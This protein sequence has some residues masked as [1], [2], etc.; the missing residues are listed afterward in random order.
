MVWAT[1][2]AVDGPNRRPNADP[3]PKEGSAKLVNAN[4][5]PPPARDAGES[6]GAA[7]RATAARLRQDAPGLGDPTKA[8]LAGL[9]VEAPVVIGAPA[10][11]VRVDQDQLLGHGAMIAGRCDGNADPAHGGP[12]MDTEG[13]ALDTE[14]RHW[15]R[16]AG[17]GHGGA[18]PDGHPH[19]PAGSI[20]AWLKSW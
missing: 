3:S 7:V 11:A 14:G 12:A 16:R 1:E 17:T 5:Q 9:V 2:R 13:P 6:G 18:A 20:R 19:P 8:N 15:T 4:A 10:V